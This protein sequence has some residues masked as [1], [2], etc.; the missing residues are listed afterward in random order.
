MLEWQEN[1]KQDSVSAELDEF[2]NT[3]PASSTHR[4]TV[5]LRPLPFLPPGC[6]VIVILVVMIVMNACSRLW[7]GLWFI[8]GIEKFHVYIMS[9]SCCVRLNSR[10]T[11][12]G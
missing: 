4:C 9:L 11:W 6:S 1:I 7:E 12:R 2:C 10:L 3:T 8:R 5:H